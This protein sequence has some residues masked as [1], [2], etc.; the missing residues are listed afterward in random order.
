MGDSLKKSHRGNYVNTIFLKSKRACSLTRW[1]SNIISR[2]LLSKNKQAGK[3]LNKEETCS[4]WRKS[5][6]NLIE[7][8]QFGDFVKFIFLWFGR[9]SFLLG[10]SSDIISTLILSK[11]K[12]RWNLQFWPKWWVNPFENVNMSTVLNRYFFVWEGLFSN[13]MI[14]KHHFKAHFVQ[15]QAK[16]KIPTFDQNL[17]LIPLEQKKRVW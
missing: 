8:I 16:R 13:W 2:P 17:G 6:V 1:S 4:F 15:K 12:L 7:K 14:R 10:L 5:W 11:T 3:C 9:A